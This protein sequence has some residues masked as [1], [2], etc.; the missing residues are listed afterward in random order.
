MLLCWCLWDEESIREPLLQFQIIA[1]NFL[2]E[3]QF[4]PWAWWGC[5]ARNA[6]CSA[7]L[8]RNAFAAAGMSLHLQ[9]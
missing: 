7:Q 1:T 5:E 9:A 2:L 3:T 6:D 4:T 8:Q